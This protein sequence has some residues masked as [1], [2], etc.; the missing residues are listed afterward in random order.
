M[1]PTTLSIFG[2]CFIFLMTTLG[3]SII[4]LLKKD[5][6]P[7]WKVFCLSFSGGIM[8]ASSIW[9]L[10]IPAIDSSIIFGDF[11]FVPACVGIL[12]GCLFMFVLD[13][14]LNNTQKQ[15]FTTKKGLTSNQ[16]MFIALSLHNIPEGLSV[17]VA[18]GS[19]LLSG[20]TASCMVALSLA[21]GIGIQNIPEG[22]AVSLPMYQQ[23]GKKWKAFLYG[24]F[25]GI[26]EPIAAVIGLVLSSF[27]SSLLP[28]LLAFAG[29]T[30]IY[31]IVNE[32][33]P[34]TQTEEN[35]LRGTWGFI[36]GFLIMMILDVAFA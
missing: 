36:A 18:I 7:K 24:M 14:F 1:E 19:A 22:L 10:I 34:E 2:I 32:L 16:K 27:V 12:L 23:T 15:V 20:S 25:S 13:K 26:L 11:A 6:S 4:F 5:M 31:T 33:L 29:G 17:G 3:A 30:M 9:S 35:K 21:I 28:W 8:M